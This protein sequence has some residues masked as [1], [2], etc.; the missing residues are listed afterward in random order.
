MTEYWVS[1]KKHYCET[2]NCWLSGHKVN[3]KN[4][5]KSA[6]HIE[7]FRRLLNESY[8]RKEEETKEKKF[9]EQELKKLENIEK[10]FRSDLNNNGGN[11]INPSSNIGASKSNL[12][13]IY[14]NRKAIN[15]NKIYNRSFNRNY[16]SSNNNNLNAVG[17]YIS[18]YNAN[19][20]NTWTLMVHEHT[21]CLLFF[22]ILTNEVSYEKPPNFVYENIQATEKFTAENGWFKYLDYNSYNNY[23][24]NIYKQLS[25]WEYSE[26]TISNLANFIKNCNHNAGG[27]TTSLVNHAECFEN[28]FAIIT[29]NGN[30]FSGLNNNDPQNNNYE[31]NNENASN[32]LGKDLVDKEKDGKKVSISVKPIIEKKKKKKEW[33]DNNLSNDINNKTSNIKINQ[34]FQHD[35]H[36]ESGE[37]IKGIKNE[38][39]SE[40]GENC[41]KNDEKKKNLNGKNGMET[42]NNNEIDIDK[43]IKATNEGIPNTLEQ[44]DESSKPGAWEV[45]EN[46]EIKTITEENIENVFYKIKTKE[47]LE[48]EHIKEIEDNLEKEYSNFN[49]F[50]VKKK[51][52]ENTELYLN[53]EFKFVNKPIYKKAIDKNDSNKVNFA[54]RSIKPKQ[55]KKKIT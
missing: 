30:D 53:Q 48:N 28:T 41:M 46:D 27:N 39:V 51:Q 20:T 9:I 45:V 22:N 40:H 44:N 43:N 26:K 35:F 11:S 12:S 13:K 52:L 21:G 50:Y 8:K 6:R 1:S 18:N 38:S 54:K 16:K 19:N 29:S 5:E 34:M 17:G 33:H 24:Y 37:N 7:N 31:S 3:I 2:C 47:E 4:H 36:N 15:N 55:A 14:D 49:E 32:I 10:Q 42:E 25:I 23:Y